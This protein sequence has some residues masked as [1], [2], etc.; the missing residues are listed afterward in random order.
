V[1]ATLID[2]HCAVKA[3][4]VPTT[5]CGTIHYAAARVLHS[6]GEGKT[7]EALPEDDLESLV[8]SLFHLTRR[9]DELVPPLSCDSSAY[10][11]IGEKWQ[12]EIDTHPALKDMV[13]AAR[14]NE[15]DKLK[16]LLS[17]F[18][19]LSVINE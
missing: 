19:V 13:L 10:K 9:K 1:Q 17:R 11:E 7:P 3:A 8:Y 12:A 6:L 2:W 5:Y 4:S 18:G 15:Y 14:A 16:E